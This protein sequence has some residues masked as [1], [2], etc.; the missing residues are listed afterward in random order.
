MW[1]MPYLLL[2]LIHGKWSLP[3]EWGLCKNIILISQTPFYNEKSISIELVN[4]PAFH[5][6]ILKYIYCHITHVL[7]VWNISCVGIGEKY[8]N[9]SMLR[10]SQVLS[11]ISNM[12]WEV[13]LKPAKWLRL[14]VD[15]IT[16]LFCEGKI[17]SQSM[18]L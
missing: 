4:L 18:L 6:G 15:C 10:S 17:E 7:E 1:N 8:H 14:V 9:C 12:T 3:I 16:V 2:R 5:V 11:T 13:S